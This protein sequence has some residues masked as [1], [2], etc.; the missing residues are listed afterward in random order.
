MGRMVYLID[1][2]NLIPHL[3]GLSLRDPDDELKLV[4][5]LQEFA[6]LS[7]AQVE[8]YFDNAPAG[9]AGRRTIGGV[10]AH[11]VA[12]GQSADSAIT[13]G[14]RRLGARARQVTVVSSDRQVLAE[15]RNAGAG[16]VTS[17]AFAQRMLQTQRNAP[18]AERSTP[19]VSQAEL[20]EWLDLFDRRK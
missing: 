8:I 2:H 19:E 1:G 14:L 9:R 20:D 5:L 12:A 13:A 6:R 3:P 7:R 16:V 4:T 11:F 10:K 15:A 18:P 17:A